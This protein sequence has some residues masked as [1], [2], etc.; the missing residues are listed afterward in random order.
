MQV[1]LSIA[2]SDSSGGAGIQADIKTAEAFGCFCATAITVVTA[3]NTLG[4]RSVMPMSAKMV[5]EQIDAVME[6]CEVGAIKI[7]MLYD[8]E[9][10]ETVGEFLLQNSL[11]IPVVLDP[12]A[13]SQAGSK[14]LKDEA[15]ESLKKLFP[16]ATLIT[17]NLEESRLFF[18]LNQ[19]PTLE[20]MECEGARY[21]RE[22]GVHIVVKNIRK[23][24]QS[25]DY[26]AQKGHASSI[27]RT[28]FIQNAQRHGTGCTF[29]SAIAC[30][31]AKG[32]SVQES[33]QRA[34]NYVHEAMIHAPMIG[35]GSGPILHRVGSLSARE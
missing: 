32:A 11:K 16:L 33:V 4:V 23:G 27:Y 12:V 24:N 2:G 30:L 25:I 35:R 26:L 10:I 7:G 17:P 18:G 8:T 19:V 21:T 15:I 3:Q 9:I 31:L 5:R 13:L 34:K 20:M 1:V 14:L 29:S 6:D 28:Q 22:L